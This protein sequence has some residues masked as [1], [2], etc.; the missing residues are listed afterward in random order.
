MN[1]HS[2]AQ[3]HTSHLV[4]PIFTTKIPTTVITFRLEFTVYL[5][6]RSFQVMQSAS[7]TKLE[8]DMWDLLE[9][10]FNSDLVIQCQ[11]EDIKAHRLILSAR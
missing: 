7:R 8:Q 11:G 6:V 10:G 4:K 3:A 9:S 1:G 5:Q 2:Q